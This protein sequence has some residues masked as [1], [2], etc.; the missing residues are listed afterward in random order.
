MKKIVSILLLVAMVFALASCAV[1]PATTDTGTNTNTNSDTSTGTSTDTDTNTGGTYVPPLLDYDTNKYEAKYA[2]S[3]KTQI[4][5]GTQTIKAPSITE[6]YNDYE[7]ALSMTFDDGADLGA[8]QLAESIMSEYGIKGTLLVN[9][10]NIQGNLSGWQKLVAGDTFDIGSHGWAHKDPSSISI[11]EMEHEI[12]DSYDFLQENFADENPIT[13]ATPLSH[14]TPEYRQYLIDTGFICNRVE[15]FGK[16]ISPKSKDVDMFNLYSKRIDT[17][18]NAE[19]NVRVNV[20][21]T[22]KSGNWFIE[23]FHNVRTKDGTDI[24]EED[25]RNHCKWLY[26]NFNGKV[27]FGSYDDV[28][29]YIAQYQTATIEYTA[30]DRD[31]MTF[32]AKV[33]KNYGQEMTLK[34]YMPFYADSAYAIING[35]EQY[36]EL[37][38]ASNSRYAYINT[39]I[40]EEGTEIKIVMGGNKLYMNNC[41]HEYVEDKVVAPTD[42][43]YGYTEM[44]CTNCEH[45]YKSEYTNKIED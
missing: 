33:D 3:K 9:I 19:T 38:K 41:N 6:Y 45:S 1:V 42:K 5:H 11:D 21:D 27:W 15:I 18:N 25:F 13:Y 39:E 34:I 2:N 10:G 40:S 24:P 44:I 14:I 7:A 35:Q 16:V 17:G 31:T 37:Q 8:A 22:L 29:K 28:A 32:L 23:L 36:L 43:A 30:C 12:K 20:S 4:K 26:D